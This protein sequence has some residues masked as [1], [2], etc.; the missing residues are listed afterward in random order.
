MDACSSRTYFIRSHLLYEPELI[1]EQTAPGGFF[2]AVFFVFQPLAKSGNGEVLAGGT[3][4]DNV[5]GGNFRSVEFRNISEVFHSPAPI[6]SFGHFCARSRR[7]T[8]RP[9]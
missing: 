7:F 8:S 3:P 2:V 6:L 1:H 9:Q 5:H 4:G